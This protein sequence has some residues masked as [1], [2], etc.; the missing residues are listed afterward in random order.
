MK[1]ELLIALIAIA[2]GILSVMIIANILG[3]ATADQTTVTAEVRNQC[4]GF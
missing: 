1:A 4:G 2:G 3:H